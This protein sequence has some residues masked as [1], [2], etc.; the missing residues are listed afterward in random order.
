MG[1]AEME[2]DW[3][4][5]GPSRQMWRQFHLGQ[6]PESKA[7]LAPETLELRPVTH[8]PRQLCEGWPP[9]RISA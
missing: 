2:G 3:R 6:V 4:E 8:L 9:A 5:R 7:C 1:K